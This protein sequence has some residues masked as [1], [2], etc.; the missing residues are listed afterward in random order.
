[1]NAGSPSSPISSSTSPPSFHETALQYSANAI[2]LCETVRDSAGKVINFRF[3]FVNRRYEELAQKP[4]EAMQGQLATVLFPNSI[5]LGIW[6]RAAE[7]VLT[8]QPYHQE[9][10]YTTNAGHTGWFDVTI[11]P[12]AD[13]GIVISLMEVS[14]QKARILAEKQQGELLQQVIANSLNGILVVESVRDEGGQV[15]D[16][17]FRLANKAAS[18]LNGYTTEQFAQSTFLTLFPT[19]RQIPFPDFD[20]TRKPQ[21]IFERYVDIVATGESVIYDV[22]YP[23]DGLSG[24]YWVAISRLNDGLIITFLDISDLKQSQQQLEHNI[25]Q[26]KQTNQNLEQFAY[27]ASHDLQEPLRKIQSFGGLLQDR[28][29]QDADEGIRDVVQRMQN[30]AQRMQELVKDLLLYSRLTARREGFGLVLLND[31]LTEALDDLQSMIVEKRAVIELAH[32]PT[33]PGHAAQLQQL[34]FCLLNN[35]LKFHKPGEAPQLTIL[36]RTPAPDQL[37]VSLANSDRRFIAVSIQD[38]GIGFDEKYKD[39]IFTIFQRL[40]GRGQ[41]GGTGIGL[42]IARK[43]AENHGGALTAQSQVGHGSAFT[44]WLPVNQ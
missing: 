10:L 17:R 16:F 39:R 3:V 26:L 30:S 41:Y 31:V 32:L 4:L 23:Y 40:H 33:V 25:T 15:I 11:S 42:A 28:L 1:M 44:V 22:Y 20:I 6:Q 21:S 8:G 35:A 34:F 9:V 29:G 7:V 38:N 13:L 36:A 24:W 27:V 19:T 37:P 2:A 12:W 14:D 18:M 43:V 5:T